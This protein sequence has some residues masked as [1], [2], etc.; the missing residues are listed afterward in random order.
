MGVNARGTCVSALPTVVL[1]R[2]AAVAGLRTGR[3]RRPVVVV[4]SF[5]PA[6]RF[7]GTGW[8]S[9][10]SSGSSW[11]VTFFLGTAVSRTAV[12]PVGFEDSISGSA[13]FRVCLTGFAG[14]VAGSSASKTTFFGRP[15]VLG[16]AL[17]SSFVF[18]V[19][20]LFGRVFDS[21]SILDVLS[22]FEAA[23]LALVGF[24]GAGTS[25]GALSISS[26]TGA[27][28]GVTLTRLR[29]ATVMVAV[30]AVAF[31]VDLFVG[32]S[33]GIVT[34]SSA[35]SIGFALRTPAD[36]AAS[37]FFGRSFVSRLDDFAA[38]AR[39]TRFAGELGAMVC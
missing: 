6:P 31:A 13:L 5:L 21:R 19:D 34:I 38:R 11:N 1:L 16:A 39:V 24:S 20:D 22:D 29:G 32:F 9:L 25:I 28:R 23:F 7:V 37:A 30:L 8:F 14:S 17:S 2:V 35:L 18:W 36:F 15:R 12:V 3:A 27:T 10:S 26:A 33:S 4:D